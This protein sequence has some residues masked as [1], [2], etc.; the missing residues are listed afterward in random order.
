MGEFLILQPDEKFSHSYDL[1]LSGS[2]LYLLSCSVSDVEPETLIRATQVMFL[3][4]LHPLELLSDGSAYGFGGTIQRDHDMNS[5]LKFVRNVIRQEF[6]RIRKTRREHRK[7]FWWP[8][9]APSGGTIMSQRV[10]SG[11]MGRRQFN[12]SGRPRLLET[13]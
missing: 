4:S 12:F 10:A 3:S 8:L 7:K 2:G 13:L 11:N 5:Y 6:N 1:L 9:V